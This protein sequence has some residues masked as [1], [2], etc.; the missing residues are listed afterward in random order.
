MCSTSHILLHRKHRSRWLDVEASRVEAHTLTY[1]RHLG[2]VRLAPREIDQP[3]LAPL[4][5]RATNSVHLWEAVDKSIA[6][7]SRDGCAVGFSKR[8]GDG[9]Q[10]L[11][12][13]I[14]C[15]RVDEIAAEVRATQDERA[16]LEV[17]CLG[18]EGG[19]LCSAIT[20]I[21][22]CDTTGPSSVRSKRP[23]GG[24]VVLLVGLF[25]GQDLRRSSSLAL[26]PY[27]RDI[28]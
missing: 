24:L 11:G 17:A 20:A 1:Q 10:L 4:T 5:R 7:D 23:P 14:G 22:A 6:R 3:R 9:L 28:I 8:S 21:A 12:A 18:K 2:S 13:K 15:G 19:G 25:G 26:P 27:R 16:V